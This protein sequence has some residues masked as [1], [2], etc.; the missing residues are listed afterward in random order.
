MSTPSRPR[1]VPGLGTLVPFYLVVVGA[2][3]LVWTA[4]LATYNSDELFVAY[5]SGTGGV[6]MLITALAVLTL[7]RRGAR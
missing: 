6:A 1:S 2:A 5:L 3:L 7:G 4:F